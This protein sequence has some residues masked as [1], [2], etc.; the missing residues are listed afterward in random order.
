M[1]LL[2]VRNDITRMQVDAIVNAANETL[3]GGGGVDGAI[4]RAAGP[5]LLAECRGL[6]GCR[7]GEAKLTAG[8]NL[9][10]KYIIHTVGPI[11]RGGGCGERALLASCYRNSLA[12]AQ[13]YG[14]ES[15]AFPMIST[16][17]YGY[18]KAEAMQVAVG[19]ITRFLM[20]SDMTVYIVVFTRDAV[21][22]GGRLF[23]EVAAYIDD[24]YVD[25][26]ADY[27]R[28]SLRAD[29]Y[30]ANLSPEAVEARKVLALPKAKRPAGKLPLPR[31]GRRKAPRA[32]AAPEAPF[33]EAAAMPAA[34][35]ADLDDMLSR[36]DES[37]AQSLLRRIDERGMTDA[38]CYRRANIDRRLFNKIKN[39]PSY[40]PGKQTALAFAIALR[41][42]LEETQDLLMKAGYALSHSSK[43][44]I[45]VEY[46]I[47]TGV[48]D[49]I[50]INE[51]LFRL[52]LPPLGY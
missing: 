3:L 32:D 44:D 10:C 15:V 24:V 45:V 38:E 36:V 47:V 42:S 8:Y 43:A 33:S 19:E 21:E 13:A 39:N 16:G 52:D 35:R 49:I 25:A 40:R 9:P 26:H 4:H 48:Y 29:G 27:G 17:V 22:L 50:A 5:G 1:P 23:G 11:W 30:A 18:P 6:G 12:L 51:V 28:E 31:L 37:F 7:T 14:C 2:F 41:L 46:C 20:D 34:P